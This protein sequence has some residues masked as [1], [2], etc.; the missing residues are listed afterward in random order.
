M[1]GHTSENTDSVESQK[2]QQALDKANNEANALAQ[3]NLEAANNSQEIAS[4]D[5]T[6]ETAMVKYEPTPVDDD[7]QQ[8]LAAALK[9]QFLENSEFD[10]Y[11]YSKK[12]ADSGYT[13]SIG[14]NGTSFTESYDDKGQPR[15]IVRV[16][17]ALYTKDGVVDEDKRLK[18]SAEAGS[19]YQIAQAEAKYPNDT[20]KGINELLA[21]INEP[22]PS[23]WIGDHKEKLDQLTT[24]HIKNLL[25]PTPLLEA[26]ANASPTIENGPAVT[27]HAENTIENSSKADE[28]PVDTSINENSVEAHP[29][30]SDQED[31]RLEMLEQLLVNKTKASEHLAQLHIEIAANE[32]Y[33]A[34]FP[35]LK[36]SYE[37]SIAIDEDI[38]NDIKQWENRAVD[39]AAE[40]TV[41]ENTETAEEKEKEEKEAR[42]AIE[43]VAGVRP[44]EGSAA[45]ESSTNTTPNPKPSSKCVQDEKDKH[46]ELKADA[47]KIEQ[48]EAERKAENTTGLAERPDAIPR[49]N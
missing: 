16:N 29:L 35:E 23:F 17:P 15:T 7:Y 31:K 45:A 21:K 24:A 13:Y 19:H 6:I 32:K 9:K 43:I 41:G 14:K 44:E 4:C 25:N 22:T 36:E 20:K 27:N 42:E 37:R 38:L 5:A 2:K 28:P 8:R 39:P 48:Q 10:T 47:E 49:P 33:F 18:L 3:K 30:N 46:P 1:T 11:E 26:G 12:N 34:N 40:I